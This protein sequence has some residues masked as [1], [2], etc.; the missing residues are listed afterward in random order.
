M[1]IDQYEIFYF[2]GIGGIGMSALA[3][4]F[5][6]RGAMVMGYDRTSTPLT[7]ELE[8]EGIAVHFDDTTLEIPHVVRLTDKSKVL[9]VYTPAIPKDSMEFNWFIEQGYTM[10]KRSQVLGLITENTR[11]I[12]VAGTHGKTTTSSMVAHI[13]T[14]SG[15]GCNAF[16][17]G[18]TSNYQSNLLLSPQSDLTVVEAD[19]Y[20]RSF[21][22]LTPSYSII[23]SMDADHLDIYG[24]HDYMLESFNL[25]A[26]KLKPNGTLIYREGLPLDK[27]ALD[28]SIEVH[29]YTLKQSADYRGRDIEIEN[30]RYYFTF[31][32]PDEKWEKIEL[33]LPGSHNVENA[34]AAIAVCL[35]L[36]LTETQIRSALRDFKGVKRR[37][38]YHIRRDDLVLIDDYAH[39]PEEIRACL[40]SVVELYPESHITGVFQPHLF[41]RTR[42]F[43][44]EFARSLEILDDIILLPI[45]PARELPMPGID[46]QML[47][48]KITKPSKKLVQKGELLA[49]LR[50]KPRQVIVMLGAGDIDALVS[51]VAAAFSV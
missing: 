45:Y 27:A 47:L 29:N 28:P 48:D 39:H 9:V 42:D 49:E 36:G 32:S 44:D 22:T 10:M 17:G 14:H 37:F 24:S 35:R 1:K 7:T 38:E 51:P 30:G 34:V 25:F 21:L 23:T 5:N 50:S 40:H 43:A 11:T 16:L 2:L 13:L 15:V 4:Y 41:S 31:Q 6:S 12:A 18:I 8:M 3:R 46:S 33:G 26:R 20:D 19:E